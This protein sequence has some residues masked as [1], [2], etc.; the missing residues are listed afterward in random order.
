MVL[1]YHSIR[2]QDFKFGAI[3]GY[4][5]CA[6]SAN[7]R[8]P[9]FHVGAK[10]E[11]SLTKQGDLYLEF[12]AIYS[13][14]KW[15]HWGF[16]YNGANVDGTTINHAFTPA[17]LQ[18][19]IRLGYKMPVSNEVK[20]FVNAGP[21]ANI[22]LHGKNKVT[23]YTAGVIES[24]SEEN[25]FGDKGLERFDVGLGV[26]VGVEFLNHIQLSGGYDYGLVKTDNIHHFGNKNRTWTLSAA[27]IF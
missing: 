3:G 26:R 21:Y 27:Y 18:V 5:H 13:A 19:P 16:K 17:Y 14:Q 20:L 11:L 12:E 4:N 8:K 23:E 24:S 22:G 7:N 25:A 6:P 15:E 10:G 1:C 2:A 9:G